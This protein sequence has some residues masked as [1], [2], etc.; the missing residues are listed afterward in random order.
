MDNR[1]FCSTGDFTVIYRLNGESLKIIDGYHGTLGEGVKNTSILRRS[2]TEDAE[3]ENFI[4]E[5]DIEDIIRLLVVALNENDYVLN[6]ESVE[7]WAALGP[8]GE[9]W[10]GKRQALVYMPIIKYF[11]L[12]GFKEFDWLNKLPKEV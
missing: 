4:Q 8:I 6:V 3:V 9:R 12:H 11:L 1:I 5:G 10:M 2:F 7:N